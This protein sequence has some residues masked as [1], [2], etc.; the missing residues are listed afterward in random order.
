MENKEEYDFY[1]VGQRHAADSVI[2]LKKIAEIYEK[3]FGRAAKEQFELGVASIYPTY[4]SFIVSTR[5]T[6]KDAEAATLNY[7][8]NNKRNNSYFNGTGTSNRFKE[9]GSYNEPSMRR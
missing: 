6:V 4:S 9:D 2:E 5:V 3:D 1:A 7:G 8:E